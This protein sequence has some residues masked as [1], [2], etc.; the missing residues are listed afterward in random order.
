[1]RNEQLAGYVLLIGV[2]RVEVRPC[3]DAMVTQ[4]HH[5]AAITPR[6]E[7]RYPYCV[8]KGKKEILHITVR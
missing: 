6:D 4:D 3:R 5:T 1:V 7:P 2:L 8:K